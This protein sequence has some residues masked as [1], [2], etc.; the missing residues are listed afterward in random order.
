MPHCPFSFHQCAAFY[1]VTLLERTT[2]R[3]TSRK[4]WRLSGEWHPLYF[5]SGFPEA[6][7]EGLSRSMETVRFLQLSQDRPPADLGELKEYL[8]TL[9]RVPLDVPNPRSTY[10]TYVCDSCAASSGARNLNRFWEFLLPTVL[11]VGRKPLK[12]RISSER[13]PSL[14]RDDVH[15]LGS[16]VSIGRSDTSRM[17]ACDGTGFVASR[18]KTRPW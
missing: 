12:R 2:V 13:P 9:V 1:I 5:Q 14:S 11:L 17:R 4:L 15:P 3:L 7:L 10:P 6:Y 16:S 8:S 18:M